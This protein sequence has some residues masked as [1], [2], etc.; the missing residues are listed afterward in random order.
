MVITMYICVC[1]K[2]TESEIA[3][4]VKSGN[5]LE[6]IIKDTGLGSQCGNCLIMARE[7][8]EKNNNG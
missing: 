5:S 3:Q 7:V 6:E 8:V 4:A 1:K 2:V